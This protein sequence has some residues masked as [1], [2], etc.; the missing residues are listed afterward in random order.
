MT[1]ALPIPSVS[2]QWLADHVG[3]DDLVVLDATVLTVTSASGRTI[4]L[5]GYD[6]YLVEGH[7]PGALFAD[8]LEE[9]SDA[10]A[11]YPLTRPTPAHFEAALAPLGIG[12]HSNVV[13]YDRAIGHWAARLWWIFRSFG[14]ENVSVLDGGLTAWS[15]GERPIDTGHVPARAAASEFSA[16]EQPG[17][18]ADK[19]D[20]EA[21]LSGDLDATLVCALAA[22]E[23]RGEA[24]DRSRLGH[25]PG[26]VSIPALRLIDR[27]DRTLLSGAPL[28]SQ[29]EPATAAQRPVI[30]YCHAGILA[31]L[32]ALALTLEGHDD[33]RVYDGSLSEWASDPA[34]PLVSETVP[35]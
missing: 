4:R 1:V 16:T 30:V 31:S 28:V 12:A 33:V 32:T 15:A 7:I 34:A 17:Y 2:A 6:E 24:G 19:A 14:F 27:D 22:N 20:V 18:W 8:L 23:F 29:L 13:I 10:S 25:I 35:V 21:V 3:T 11:P 26:S 9:F 5:S